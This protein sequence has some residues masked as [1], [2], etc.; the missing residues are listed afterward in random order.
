MIA[1]TRGK[2]VGGEGKKE[3]RGLGFFMTNETGDARNSKIWVA[4]REG[5]ERLWNFGSK[6]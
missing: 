4:G 5:R 2:L 1:R 3:E 6:V